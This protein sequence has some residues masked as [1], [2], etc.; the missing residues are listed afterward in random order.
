MKKLVISLLAVLCASAIGIGVA[1]A[2]PKPQCQAVFEGPFVFQNSETLEVEQVGEVKVCAT[3]F[4][5][6]EIEPVP[7]GTYQI[8]YYNSL[9]GGWQLLADGLEPVD[10]ELKYED[11]MEPGAYAHLGFGVEAGNCLANQTYVSGV[12]LD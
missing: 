7:E 1:M 9:N 5:K 4:V 3:G 10:G 12:V 8:C 2:Q 11:Y 6:A